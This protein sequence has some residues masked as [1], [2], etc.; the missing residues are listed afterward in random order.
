MKKI[1]EAFCKVEEGLCNAGFVL[2]IAL[3]FISALARTAGKPLAWSIDVAQLMLCWTT[4]IGADIAF[5]HGR[6]MGLDLI[7]R[8][9]PLKVQRALLIF[10]DG[11]IFCALIIFAI[12][13]TRLS[14][15]SRLRSFQ[16]LTISYSWVTI[17]L[18]VMSALMLISVGLDVVKRVKG[19]NDPPQK[20][21]EE[22][23]G[24]V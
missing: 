4:L 2:M 5:R 10:I 11:L 6:F 23:E 15:E 19:F 7:T 21:H 20:E 12:Y 22:K 8:H 18:P 13:G 1:Y 24:E 17:A 14:I 3:V 9:F 16:T